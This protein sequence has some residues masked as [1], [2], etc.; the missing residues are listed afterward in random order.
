MKHIWHLAVQSMMIARVRAKE[1]EKNT[2]SSHCLE[3]TVFFVGSFIR[4]IISFYTVTLKLP[5][6]AID[7][8][9]MQDED[10]NTKKAIFIFGFGVF[11]RSFG[12]RQACFTHH[13]NNYW[14]LPRI[15]CH[16]CH[17][18]ALIHTNCAD[19]VQ[20]PATKKNYFRRKTWRDVKWIN[21]ER[22]PNEQQTP[23]KNSRFKW[24]WQRKKKYCTENFCTRT[25]CI[26]L[27]VYFFLII[28]FT[29]R[30]IGQSEFSHWK[31]AG[32]SECFFLTL[33]GSH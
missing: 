29:L 7:N 27:I 21:I 3:M 15:E 22:K 16:I 33:I 18:S 31:L 28:F 8:V 20:V 19:H 12:H 17:S 24:L 6:K 5:F 11:F 23:A 4:S 25:K 1:M 2:P 14:L 9:S 26:Q 30:V 32:H 10:E 13:N